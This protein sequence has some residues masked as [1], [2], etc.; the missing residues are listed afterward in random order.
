MTQLPDGRQQLLLA[1]YKEAWANVGRHILVVWQSAGVVGAT[2]A[3][4]TLVEKELLSIDIAATFEVLIIAWMFAHIVDAE[5]WFRR[6]IHII[7]NIERQ[8]LTQTDAREIHHYFLG[9]KTPKLDHLLVQKGLAVAM[10]MLVLVMH[11]SKSSWDGHNCLFFLP[12]IAL[13]VSA[14]L[15]AMFIQSQRSK[16]EILR[17]ESPG[18]S[19][20]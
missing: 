6:N 13:V 18:R 4:F 11:I 8:F 10:L 3:V 7:S 16:Y 14:F 19:V 17:R 5:Y 2:L 9:S 15:I 12:W 20:P 1:M